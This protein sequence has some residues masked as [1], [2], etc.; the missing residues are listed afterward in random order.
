M[1]HIWQIH[2]LSAVEYKQYMYLPTSLGILTDDARQHLHDI[3]KSN[4]I[5]QSLAIKGQKTR[6]KKGHTIPSP[7]AGKYFPHSEYF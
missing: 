5:A 2:G 4:G 6:F 7:N 1:A 3:V